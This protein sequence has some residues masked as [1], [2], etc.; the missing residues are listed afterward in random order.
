MTERATESANTF[1]R[2]TPISL[3]LNRC[4]QS[5]SKIFGDMV[6]STRAVEG[7]IIFLC[8]F[9]ARDT[10]FRK[11]KRLDQRTH[12]VLFMFLINMVKIGCTL[13]L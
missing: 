6:F 12:A 1:R 11:K 4:F 2:I 7:H 8:S 5:M 13:S 3:I 10:S 9:S